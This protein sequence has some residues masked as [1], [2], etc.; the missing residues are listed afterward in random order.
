MDTLRPQAP[1]RLAIVASNTTLRWASSPSACSSARVVRHLEAIHSAVGLVASVIALAAVRAAGKPAD[2]EHPFGHGK[3]ENIS[4]AIE[5]F[6]IF[7]AG[8]WIILEFRVVVDALLPTID[9]T[10]WPITSCGG[11]APAI[12]T[13]S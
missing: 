4:G 10:G 6:L 9:A 2:E 12:R 11:S 3:V 8:T 13:R 7:V 5:A 1:R